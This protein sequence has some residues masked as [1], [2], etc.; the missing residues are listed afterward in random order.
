MIVN[1]VMLLD[2]RHSWDCASRSSLRVVGL[3]LIYKATRPVS[4]GKRR[5]GH[6][7]PKWDIA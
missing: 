5:C 4:F 3:W 7:S 6:T 1:L 2:L